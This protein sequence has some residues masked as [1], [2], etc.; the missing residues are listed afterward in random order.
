LLLEQKNI[1][2]IRTKNPEHWN[3]II[4][5]LYECK[6]LTPPDLVQI[7][8]DT[9]PLEKQ[10]EYPM[11]MQPLYKIKAELENIPKTLAIYQKE[12][13]V[14]Q[15]GKCTNEV[16]GSSMS[17]TKGWQDALNWVIKEDKKK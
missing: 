9:T 2:P 3:A 4:Q 11:E 13:D 1:L 8:R 5:T 7:W 15:Y 16:S 12:I 6:W 17:Y 14:Q 10:E